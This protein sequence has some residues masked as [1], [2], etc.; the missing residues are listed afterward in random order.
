LVSIEATGTALDWLGALVISADPS[1]A[2]LDP[3]ALYRH[4]YPSAPPIGDG[5]L[6]E[7]MTDVR[8]RFHF[9]GGRPFGRSTPRDMGRLLEMIH[10][11]TCASRASC[12]AI[13]KLLRAQHFDAG[14]P[15]YLSGAL[16]AHKTGSFGP[17]IANDVGIIEGPGRPAV[18]ACFF[19][20]H[21]RGIYAHLE[22]AIARMSEKVWEYAAATA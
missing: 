9:E 17:F 1:A 16:A 22:D 20:T 13:L 3:A 19:T 5:W 7:R 2:H 12:D 4:G 21:Y 10:A 14:M 18:I 15:R 6:G 8:T 11:G